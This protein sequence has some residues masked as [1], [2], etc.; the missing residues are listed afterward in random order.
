MPTLHAYQ[1]AGV[2]W[3]LARKPWM[4]GGPL[5]GLLGDGPGTGKT[6]QALEAA[7]HVMK[8][9]QTADI[10]VVT[11]KSVAPSW[12]AECNLWRPDLG[13]CSDARFLLTGGDGMSL[14]GGQ[15]GGSRAGSAASRWSPAGATPSSCGA[16]G[17]ACS[18]ASG[19]RP[20]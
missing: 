20:S 8:H 5:R 18:G 4:G 3:L 9:G 13:V 14:R 6:V 16:G 15:V 17:W 19:P 10:L 12:E 7:K 11:T 1:R 2:E